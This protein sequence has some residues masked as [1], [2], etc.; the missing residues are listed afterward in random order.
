MNQGPQMPQMPAALG[1]AIDNVGYAVN[2]AADGV[3]QNINN[4]VSDFSNNGAVVASS[5]FLQSN[6]IIAKFS[7]LILVV[8][9]FI[10]LFNL[11]IQIIGYFTSVDQNPY[12]VKG[13]IQG[14]NTAII[15]QDPNISGSKPIQRSNNES[16]G[17]EFTW[18]C[19]LLYKVDASSKNVDTYQPVFVKGDCSLQPELSSTGFYS[20]NN[21]PGV[22]FGKSSNT[23]ENGNPMTN[24]LWILMD[25]IPIPSQ[26]TVDKDAGNLFNAKKGSMPSSMPSTSMPSTSMPTTSM[27]TTTPEQTFQNMEGFSNQFNT[28]GTEYMEIPNIPINKYF[29]LAI[30]CQNKYIDVYI[31]GTVVYRVD[32]VNVP[33]QNY[34]DI[35]VCGKGG[36]N[37]NLSNL[38]YYSKSLSVIE[39]NDIV[40]KGPD[41][42]VSSIAPN[43]SAS[44]VGSA[45]LSNI[46]YNKFIY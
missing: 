23:D 41:L 42:N 37:G 12:I 14:T 20:L 18:S 1:N 4:V 35:E 22:Y 39:I 34:Y 31:N 36:F 24:S 33:K 11:G 10:V 30:R 15:S 13:Q 43:N 16:S 40:M 26:S 2:N 17:I 6:T 27:P 9:G 25:T 32:L 46:W 44:N 3:K 5:S 21:A 19:W 7:F 29:H 8:V 45:Y 28:H 38:R